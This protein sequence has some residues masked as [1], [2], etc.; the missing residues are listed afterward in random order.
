MIEGG[1]VEGS[2]DGAEQWRDE[3]PQQL[4]PGKKMANNILGEA[5]HQYYSTHVAR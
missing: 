1:G 5:L 3:E 4:I 2:V